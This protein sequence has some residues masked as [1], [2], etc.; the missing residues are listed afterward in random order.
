LMAAVAR[1]SSASVS[2]AA[3]RGPLEVPLWIMATQPIE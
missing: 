1:W 2:L 3:W